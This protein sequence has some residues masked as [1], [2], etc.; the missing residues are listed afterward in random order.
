ME[1]GPAPTCEVVGSEIRATG[2]ALEQEGVEVLK[3]P[4]FGE[5]APAQSLLEIEVPLDGGPKD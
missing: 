3:D 1:V 4:A 5:V 2:S